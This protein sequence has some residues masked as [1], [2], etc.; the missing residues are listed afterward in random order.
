MAVTLEVV[1][2]LNLPP[3]DLVLSERENAFYQTLKLP[4]RRTEWLGGRLALKKLL[5][6]HFGGKQT[7]FSI[8]A[9]GGVGKPSIWQ[10]TKPVTIPFS[11]THSNG[12]AIAVVDSTAL[13]VGIDLERIAP[14]IQAWKNDFFHPSEL[15]A[16]DDAFLTALWTQKEALVKL[17]GSG[18][19]INSYEVRCI[20]GNPQFLGKALQIY[21]NLGAPQ[22]TLTTSSNLL[23]GFQFSIAVGN[24]TN[25]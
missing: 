3:S 20:G 8:L 4:K 24:L 17:L 9:A 21:Q 25:F 14:R 2:L 13:C 15:L 7:D 16:Q 12:Y 10:G 1:N 11:L 19:T 5:V 23:P 22:I 6:S 18:L